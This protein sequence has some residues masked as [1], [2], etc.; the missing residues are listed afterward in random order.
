M[1]YCDAVAKAGADIVKFQNHL[2]DPQNQ[3]RPGTFFPADQTRRAYWERTSF[4]TEEWRKLI[5]HAHQVGLGFCVSVFSHEA[6]DQLEELPVDLWKLGSAQVSSLDLVE[7]MAQFREPLI[8]SS[9]MSDWQELANAVNLAVR[10]KA[11]NLLSP[12]VRLMHCVS[13][14]PCPPEDVGLNIL[15]EM[16]SLYNELQVGLS[17]HSGTIWP[18]IA[19][20]V[21]GASMAEVHVCWHRECF[22][23]DVP[24]SITIDEL[25]QLVQGVRFIEQ[26][27]PVDK[28]EQAKGMEDMRRLFRV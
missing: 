14:Y 24:A 5:D 10:V 21:R 12:K 8:V 3:F 11:N 19:A 26:M 27:R 4:T 13:K 17:D 23:P 28:N 15:A 18:S 20:A 6:I 7:R 25:K 16:S 9:G 22:G 2:S 1:A